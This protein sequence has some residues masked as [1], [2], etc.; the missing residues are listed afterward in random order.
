MSDPFGPKVK[1]TFGR[2]KG[3]AKREFKKGSVAKSVGSRRGSKASAGSRGSKA[4]S[5]GSGGYVVLSEA[6]GD[7]M[8]RWWTSQVAEYDH[9]IGELQARCDQLS[10]LHE[11]VVTQLQHAQGCLAVASKAVAAAPAVAAVAAAAAAPAVAAASFK[12]ERVVRLE[13]ELAE[14]DETISRLTLEL[15]KEAKAHAELKIL[16]LQHVF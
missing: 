7:H 11:S 15:H 9:K 8:V 5:S 3:T 14:R 2:G 6:T 16:M 12:S 13:R 1:F 4:S 10:Q